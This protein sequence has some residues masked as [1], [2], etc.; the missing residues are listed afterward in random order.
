MSDSGF[1]LFFGSPSG[2]IKKKTVHHSLGPTEALI[3]QTHSGVCATDLELAD[4]DAALGHEGI[5]IVEELGSAAHLLSD[6]KVGDRVG[7]GWV[8]RP[9]MLSSREH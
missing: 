5:G 7:F 8:S 1:T 6:V 2:G 9:L 3:R 4:R